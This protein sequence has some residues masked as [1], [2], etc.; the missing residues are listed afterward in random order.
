MFNFHLSFVLQPI[1]LTAP[2]WIFVI[3]GWTPKGSVMFGDGAQRTV[4]GQIVNLTGGGFCGGIHPSPASEFAS[5]Q[6][7]ERLAPLQPFLAGF[8]AI[9]SLTDVFRARTRVLR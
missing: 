6:R 8:P 4:S 9:S 3:R 2:F 5:I 7:I 1:S